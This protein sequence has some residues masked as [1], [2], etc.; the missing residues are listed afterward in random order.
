MTTK[1]EEKLDDAKPYYPEVRDKEWVAMEMGES[2]I[3]RSKWKRRWDTVARIYD[4]ICLMIG[5]AMAIYFA[6][7]AVAGLKANKE[8]WDAHWVA[9]ESEMKQE[10]EHMMKTNPVLV[11]MQSEEYLNDM[12]QKGRSEKMEKLEAEENRKFAVQ[13]LGEETVRASEKEPWF[14]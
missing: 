13:I 8:Y 12:L 14:K 6:A 9:K 7:I 2:G 1:Q 10:A 11:Y 5:V 3:P 4:R